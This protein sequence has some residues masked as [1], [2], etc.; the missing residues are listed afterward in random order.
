LSELALVIVTYNCA[1]ELPELADAL[2]GVVGEHD[3]IVLVDNGSGDGTPERGRELGFRVLE[4]GANL[5][6]GGGCRV[7]ADATRAP[8][9]LFLNPDARPQQ[10][11]LELLR[12]VASE[13]PAW[14][15]WQP[16]VML[17]DGRINTAGGVVHFLGLSWAGRCERPA[18]ELGDA[19]A[20]IAFASGAALVIRRS[21]W[22]ELD[23]FDDS[24]FLYGEDMELGLRLWLAGHRVGIEPRAR[25]V[26]DYV[27]DKGRRKWFL[28]ERNRWRALLATYP[29]SLLALL[30]PALLAAELGLLVVAARDRW[31]VAKLRADLATLLGLGGPPRARPPRPTPRRVSAGAF[32][33]RLTASLDSPYIAQLPRSLQRAQAAYF[34]LVRAL[35]RSSSRSPVSIADSDGGQRSG[36]REAP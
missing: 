10:G 9:L 35:L 3:E 2:R 5:G 30:A 18:S 29:A 20:E 6:F 14:A 11:S 23:G 1:G 4:S 17:P 32:S 33:D 25:V 12:A 19:P 26:H 31:L 7:G 36:Q 16:A 22:D 28:L 15:A 27:F 34:A 13:Q 21:A 24:Y 8:L